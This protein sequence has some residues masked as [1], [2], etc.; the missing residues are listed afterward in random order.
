MSHAV[1]GDGFGDLVLDVI[2]ELL[3]DQVLGEDEILHFASENA[4]SI[5][6]N[7]SE[8]PVK[9]TAYLISEGLQLAN[10]LS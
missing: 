5:E 7:D 6:S 3:V 9:L 2:D 8:E 1:G 4:D 10:K